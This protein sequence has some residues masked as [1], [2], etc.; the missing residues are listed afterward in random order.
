[1]RGR[2]PIVEVG[3][4]ESV[5]GDAGT[6]RFFVVEALNGVLQS[7]ELRCLKGNIFLVCEFCILMHDLFS[8][9]V[10]EVQNEVA[11]FLLDLFSIEVHFVSE[12]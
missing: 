1:M 9:K 3:F 2:R 6:Q 8:V 11:D 12:L 10:I 7:L 5:D 4:A